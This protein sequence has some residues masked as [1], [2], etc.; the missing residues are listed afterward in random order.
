[1]N[2][3]KIDKL[4]QI[5]EIIFPEGLIVDHK[6][7]NGLH[8]FTVPAMPGIFAADFSYESALDQL[9]LKL[10]KMYDREELKDIACD[11]TLRTMVTNSLEVET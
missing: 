2:R 4:L 6:N 11:E 7:E 1:M 5:R 10:L 3:L 9:K 8:S